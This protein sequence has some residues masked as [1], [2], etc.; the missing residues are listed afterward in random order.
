MVLRRVIGHL[1]KQ[2]WTLIAIDFVILVFGVFLGMQVQDWNSDRQARARADVFA[3]RLRSDLKYEEWNYQYLENYYGE[4]LANAG[5]AIDALT[6]DNAMDDEQFVISAYRA[7]QY[8]FNG[9]RRATYDELVSTGTIGLISDQELRSTAVVVYNDDLLNEVQER[10]A[11]SDYRREFRR[12]APARLQHALLERCGDRIVVAGDVHAIVNS[13]DYP[14]DLGLPT[15]Q[16]A[17]AA[18]ALRD[19]PGLLPALGERFADLETAAT[20]LQL[21]RRMAERGEVH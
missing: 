4:V 14:C 12:T 13:L 16:I 3:E 6:G 17:D 1:R 2:E 18:K 5:R 8:R 20:D 11:A 9:R 19:N 21:T 7:S 15:A 10:S